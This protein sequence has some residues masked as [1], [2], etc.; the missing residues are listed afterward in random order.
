[1]IRSLLLVSLAL[2]ACSSVPPVPEPPTLQAQLA[3]RV[4]VKVE[5]WSGTG[6]GFPL[7]TTEI[8]T[9]WHVVEGTI[10]EG[11]TVNGQHPSAVILLG[12]LD[13]CVLRFDAPHGLVPWALDVRAVE[14][15]EPVY[16]SG[17]G[18]GLHW[19]SAGLGTLEPHRLSLTIAPG[20]S[21]CPVLD[22]DMEVIGIVVARGMLGAHHCFIVPITDIQAELD[23]IQ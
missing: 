10:P 6:S 2:S 1:M 9:A 3:S 19:W 16:A 21:G 4:A 18:V 17:W 14:P 20:D 7:S 23:L 11:I 22:S 15:A 8:L 13:A 5:T 12:A